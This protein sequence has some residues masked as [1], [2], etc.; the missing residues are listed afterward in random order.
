MRK[1]KA[2]KILELME[3]VKP[4]KG[5]S[6]T[7]YEG[8]DVMEADMIETHVSAFFRSGEL[9]PIPQSKYY[10]IEPLGLDILSVE[11]TYDKKNGFYYVIIEGVVK[12]LKGMEK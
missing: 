4:G 6:M 1:T 7:M 8:R 11:K 12:F 3:T 9:F 10:S 5:L 2:K